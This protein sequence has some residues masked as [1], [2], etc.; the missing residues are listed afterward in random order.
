MRLVRGIII[1]VSIYATFIVAY[2][3]AA[4]VVTII[5]L[6]DAVALPVFLFIWFFIPGILGYLAITSK[7]YMVGNVIGFML[8]AGFAAIWGLTLDVWFTLALLIIFAFYDYIS[9]YK[10]KHMIKLAGLATS[11]SMNMLFVFPG[12]KDFNPA[13]KFDLPEAGENPEGT[14]SGERGILLGFGDVALPNVMVISSTIYGNYQ[15]FPY[16]FLPLLGAIAGIAFL[17]FYTKKPAPGLPLINTGVI[18]GFLLA[19]LIPW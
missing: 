3:I 19:F 13:N 2:A 12:S 4:V 8:S 7:S 11:G 5:P 14:E 1:L 10:T 15:L 6:Q 9:V 18:I 17:M 16:F